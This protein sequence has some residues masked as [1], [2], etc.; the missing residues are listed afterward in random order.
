MKGEPM[1]I[2]W[3][4][5]AMQKAFPWKCRKYIVI[6]E[7]PVHACYKITICVDVGNIGY[8]EEFEVAKNHDHLR[9]KF[10]DALKNLGATVRHEVR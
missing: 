8:E 3:M 9:C 7:F 4:L 10:E 2:D 6:E 1:D 5:C